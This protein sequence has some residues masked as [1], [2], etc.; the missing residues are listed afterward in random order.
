MTEQFDM[1]VIDRG[2]A[3]C[4]R[5]DQA[6]RIIAAADAGLEH[7]EVALA[8][9]KMQAGQREQGLKTS[10]CFAP[11]LR[12]FGDRGFDPRRQTCQIAMADLGAIHRKP[13]V[14]TIGRRRGEESRTQAMGAGDMSAE[15]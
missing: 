15:C 2:D 7:R 3:A 14:E 13:L 4:E 10:E 9:L 8:F 11:A 6:Y 5:A 1:L 12:D